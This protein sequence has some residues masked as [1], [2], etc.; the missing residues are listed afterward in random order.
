MGVPFS[1][2]AGGLKR[3]L[4]I[5]IMDVIG[6]LMERNVQEYRNINGLQFRFE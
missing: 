4:K 5:N 3:M 2:G 6:I 1:E